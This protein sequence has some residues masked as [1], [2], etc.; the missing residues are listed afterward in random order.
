MKFIANVAFV[1]SL[2]LLFVVRVSACICDVPPPPCYEYWRTD[3]VFVGSV[4]KVL[5]DPDNPA[6]VKV[7]VNVEKNFKGMTFREA[8][9][10]NFGHSCAWDFK[11]GQRFLFY[12]GL[13][14]NNLF[15]FWNKFLSSNT[16]IQRRSD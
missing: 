13:N 8:T 1:F 3:A 7:T 10:E 4:S 16:G 15:T 5:H 11:E 9:T 2:S 12:A 14:R 6:D